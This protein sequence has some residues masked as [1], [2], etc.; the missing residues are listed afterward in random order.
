MIKHYLSLLLL[1]TYSY[2]QLNFYE[3]YIVS[4]TGDTIKGEIKANP[5]RELPLFSKVMFR[6]KQGIIKTYKPEK[7]KGFAYFNTEKNKW[8]LFISIN[9]DEPKF[10][11]ISIQYPVSIYEYQYEDM[12]MGTF[13]TAKSYFIK[14]NNQ[15]VPLKSKKMKKQFAPYINNPAVL[16]ELDKMEVIDIEKLSLLFEKHYSKTTL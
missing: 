5:K 13:Y 10:Y 9:D 1:T 8:H 14:E 6:D 3:G 4:E 11:K 15:F 16:D 2:A 12:K 7:I